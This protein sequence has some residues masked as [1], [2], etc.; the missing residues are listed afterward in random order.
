MVVTIVD[1]RC[2]CVDGGPCTD[3]PHAKC[4]MPHASCYMPEA[5]C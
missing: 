1:L 2:V 3:H 4:Y 5:H